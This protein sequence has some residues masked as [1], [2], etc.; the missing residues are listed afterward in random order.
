MFLVPYCRYDA[1]KLSNKGDF[2]MTEIRYEGIG[3]DTHLRFNLGR[4]VCA[5]K[6]LDKN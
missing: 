2:P 4:L 5:G 6:Y 3:D 1:G